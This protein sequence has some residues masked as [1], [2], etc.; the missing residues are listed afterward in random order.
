MTDANAT[1][2]IVIS[3]PASIL[4][5]YKTQTSVSLYLILEIVIILIAVTTVAFSMVRYRN[6]QK[7]KQQNLNEPAT[8]IIKK[9]NRLKRILNR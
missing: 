2:P 6:L 8:P 9:A 4:G 3:Q 5:S 7:K 1:S